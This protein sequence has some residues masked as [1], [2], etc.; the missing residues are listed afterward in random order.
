[1]K[2]IIFTSIIAVISVLSINNSFAQATIAMD[3]NRADCNGTMHHLFTNDLDSGNVVILEFFMGGGCAS[4]IAAGHTLE[5]MKTGLLAAHPGKI[6]A[7]T[8]GYSNSMNCATAMSWISS[9][10][11]TST[12]IDSGA[13]QVAYYGGFGMPTIVILA[14]TSHRVIYT[15][16]GFSSSD[17][18]AMKDSINKFFN[19]AS[20]NVANVN[21]SFG[22]ISLFPNPATNILSIEMQ[23]MES[24]R[25]QIQIADITGKTISIVGDENVKVGSFSKTINISN[26]ANGLYMVK[27][28]VNGNTSYSKLT[29]AK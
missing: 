1:M 16:I 11:F 5:S 7:Y 21:A 6:R 10:G 3:F 20:T 24:G 12:P 8:S 28:T 9:N 25:L 27:A 17:T 14:G 15:D 2:K 13:A 26:F 23:L 18:T 4:C 29:I 22:S 19:P